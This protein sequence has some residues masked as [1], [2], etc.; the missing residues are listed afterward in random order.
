MDPQRL[1][2]QPGHGVQHQGQGR[3][4]VQVRMGQKHIVDARHLLRRQFAHAGSGV[5]E[6]ALADQE[7]GG[8]TALGDGA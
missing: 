5:D 6:H 7:G 3:D 4:V 2:A 1:G 8:V